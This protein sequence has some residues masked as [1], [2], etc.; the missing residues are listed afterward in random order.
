MQQAR[1]LFGLTFFGTLAFF[2]LGIIPSNPAAAE[3]YVH[4]TPVTIAW[5]HD[6]PEMVHHYNV[7]VSV[8]DA[9]F[10]LAGQ[11]SDLQYTLQVEDRKRYVVQVDAEDASGN[12]S[13]LSDPLT[14]VIYLNGSADDTDGDGMNDDWEVSFLFNPFDPSDGDE[15]FDGD[16]LSNAEEFLAGT[17]PTNPDTDQDGIQDGAEAQAGLD[18]LDPMDNA[19]VADAGE[20]QDLDPT[21]V[22]LDG[23]GSFDPN[24]DPLA[25]EWSQLDGAGVELSNPTVSTPN[26]LGK[27]WGL[28]RFELQ[29]SDGTVTSVPDEVSVTIRNVAPTAD[30]GPD[31]VVDAGT[32][33]MLDGSGSR[34]PNGDTLSC[35]WSQAE[36]PAVALEDDL[37]CTSTLVPTSS[38]VHVFELIVSD[39]QLSSTADQAQVVV[40]AVNQVP[41]A[42]AGEDQLV[43]VNDAVTLDGSGSTDPDGDPLTYAWQQA[44]GPATVSLEGASSEAATFTPPETG[45]YRFELVVSD[46]ETSSAPDAVTVTVENEN[47]VPVAMVA[48]MDGPVTVGDWVILDGQAS[49][50]PDGDTLG[51]LWTQAAGAQVSLDDPA[52]Q[53]TGFY[54]VTE[55][56]LK[57]QLMVEDGELTSAPA[58]VEVT[59]D[60]GN[61]VPVADAGSDLRGR[62]GQQ[63]CLDGS[64][65]YDPDPG[66][67]IT[68]LWSQTGGPLLTLYGHDTPAPCF[69]P[70]VRGKYTFILI[71]SDGKLQSAPDTVTVRVRK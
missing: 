25:Y 40:N 45:T 24:G 36:G 6:T 48:Q 22:T 3:V 57:F 15:D 38:G 70:S 63:Y 20:D 19:P 8:D 18:P 31:Q 37:A 29:V 46:G 64:G 34:D 12:R 43:L 10:E 54:A 39:G 26:F 42:N 17:V 33:V 28:Y 23:S 1:G 55:G 2:F 16:G 44:E 32:Q 62:V 49:Y 52:A 69:V 53:V 5:D 21:V 9:P 13:T 14:A 50:D 71:V 61:Q 35:S 59:V 11:P 51:Y 7:Y 65:S 60:G 27:A 41:T 47:R 4:Y 67:T 30:A 66:D 68:Y 58:F 56:V